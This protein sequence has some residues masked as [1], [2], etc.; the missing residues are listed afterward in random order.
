M[1]IALLDSDN[2]DFFLENCS[3][4]IDEYK[5]LKPYMKELGADLEL[6]NWK[7]IRNNYKEFDIIFPKRCWDYSQ[8]YPEY[9]DMLLEL[10]QQKK[11]M[12]NNTDLIIWNSHKKYLLDL[13][14][15]NLNVGEIIIINKNT[16]NYFNLIQDFISQNLKSN[17]N[18]EFIAKPA[19]GLGGKHVFKFSKNDIFEKKGEFEEI[20][21]QWDLVVQTFFSEIKDEGE[22]S[23]FFFNHKFSHAIKKIPAINSILAHQLFGAKNLSYIPSLEE[24]NEAKKFISHINPNYAR[25]DLVKHNGKMYLIEL[26]LI[27]PY[28]YLNE[29]MT[30]NIY[31]F[32][33]SILG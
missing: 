26:E 29:N 14:K 31:A 3:D 15:L 25:I 7:N 22:L 5:L 19:I 16:D 2:K 11:K 12:V 27:E 10:K 17:L 33:K 18:I 23:F 13:K 24:I 6:I 8:N 32:C 9:L 28:L 20:L 1:K 4:F 30:E 21:S